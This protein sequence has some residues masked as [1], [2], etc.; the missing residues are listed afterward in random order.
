MGTASRSPP[1]G[2]LTA[3]ELEVVALLCQGRSSRQTGKQL[4]ISPRTVDAH[5]RHI[6]RKLSARNRLEAVAIASRLGLPSTTGS[7]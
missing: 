7:L 6:L 5:V 2:E 3:R 4:G 1:G